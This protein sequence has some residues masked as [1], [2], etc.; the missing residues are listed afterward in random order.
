[1]FLNFFLAEHN[2][3][4]TFT[5]NLKID[6]IPFLQLEDPFSK[7]LIEIWSNVSFKKELNNFSQ[8]PIWYNSLIRIN[9]KPFYYRNW[10]LADIR[11]VDH[12][13]DNDSKL[14]TFDTF[15]KK[16]SVKTKFLQYYSVV[17]AISGLKNVCA[18]HPTPNSD[19]DTKNLMMSS[20]FCKS[21]YKNTREMIS[22]TS[23]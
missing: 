6:D 21:A 16:Y 13:F 8:M 22:F 11:P 23:N 17:C 19:D 10:C 2:A 5:G 7:E 9:N 1:M 20:E 3:K 4:L 18:R 15:K 12:L 14:L